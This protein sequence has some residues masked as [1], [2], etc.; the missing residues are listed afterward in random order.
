MSTGYGSPAWRSSLDDAMDGII[1]RLKSH[2]SSSYYS[3]STHGSP[4]ESAKLAGEEADVALSRAEGET[5]EEF[6]D[7]VLARLS[8]RRESFRANDCADPDGYVCNALRELIEE[9]ER[10]KARGFEETQKAVGPLSSNLAMK[11]PRWLFFA[12]IALAMV[13]VVLFLFAQMQLSAWG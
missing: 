12:F 10:C 11:P 3:P 2:A 6:C 13:P 9:V 8:E 7:S 5:W 4:W 1:R